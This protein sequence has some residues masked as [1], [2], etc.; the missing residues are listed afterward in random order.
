[1]DRAF[2]QGITRRLS[3]LTV[4]LLIATLCAALATQWWFFELFSHFAPHYAVFALICLAGLALTHA[5]HWAAVALALVLWNAYP[6]VRAL[7]HD[8]APPA[9][10]TRQFTVFHL[11]VGLHHEQPGRVSSFLLRRAKQIDVVVL[12]EA[13]TSF[14]FALDEI[15]ALYPYQIRHLEDSPFGIALASKHPIDFGAVSFKPSRLYPHIEATLKLP[16]RETPLL[17]MAL[18]APPPISS[19]MAHDRNLK[20]DFISRV[21]QEQSK[22]TPVVVGDFNLTPWSPYF[23]KFAADSGLRNARTPH[24]F[25]HTWPVTFDNANIGLAIDHSFAHPSLPLIKRVLGPDLGSD[26]MPVTVTFGY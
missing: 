5:W 15:K 20:F 16:G 7:L 14:E 21:A 22:A 4:M 1:M 12:L 2:R 11:N 18:H 9:A 25:E 10:A 24:R 17:L 13:T 6:V 23:Q 8:D 26:H 19:E 3:M